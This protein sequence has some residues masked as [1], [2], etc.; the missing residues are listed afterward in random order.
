MTLCKKHCLQAPR[1][2]T[3]PK[4]S[5][6]SRGTKLLCRTLLCSGGGLCFV[7]GT[8]L[9]CVRLNVIQQS[10]LQTQ[11]HGR[12]RSPSE[13]RMENKWGKFK[14]VSVPFD[15]AF[16]YLII[17]ETLSKNYSFNSCR[18]NN[19]VVHL[20]PVNSISIIFIGIYVHNAFFETFTMCLNLKQNNSVTAKYT[21]H[22]PRVLANTVKQE[23]RNH[24]YAYWKS[25]DKVIIFKW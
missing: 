21:L 2:I 1:I 7:C 15:L 25:R 19:V 3:K 23:N 5:T 4:F 8:V 17:T 11:G 22:C 9:F 24:Q 16:L 14:S 6:N 12:E 18:T 13:C 10:Q 20:K